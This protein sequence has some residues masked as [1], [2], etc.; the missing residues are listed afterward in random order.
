MTPDGSLQNNYGSFLNFNND[1]LRAIGLKPETCSF[2]AGV[3]VFDIDEWRKTNITGDL[4]KWTALN[5]E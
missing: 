4:E 2:N 1:R 3:Y 5:T